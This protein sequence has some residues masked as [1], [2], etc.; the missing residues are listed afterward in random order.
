MAASDPNWAEQVTAIATAVGAIGLLGTIVLA[1]VAGRQVREVRHSRQAQIAADFLR[2]WDEPDLVETRRLVARFET[3]EAL[4]AA[5]QHYMAD[6]SI[7]AFVFYR[8]LDYFEQLGALERLGAIHFDLVELLLGQRLLDR[9]E[10]WKPSID[11]MGGESVYPMFSALVAKMRRA[12]D[13]RTLFQMS[14]IRSPDHRG[15]R[16]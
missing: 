12:L 5:F 3:K 6:N 7:E 16:M 1:V 10:M 9:W 2:R 13:T 11:A 4:C 15:L 8:E 14:S